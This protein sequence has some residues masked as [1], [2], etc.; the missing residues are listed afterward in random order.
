MLRS[1]PGATMTIKGAA[2]YAIQVG[3]AGFDG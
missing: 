1:I 3:R 2:G